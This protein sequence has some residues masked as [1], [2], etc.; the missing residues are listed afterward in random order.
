MDRF[1]EWRLLR[2][3]PAVVVH[4]AKSHT[5]CSG[6]GGL[7]I[8]GIRTGLMMRVAHGCGHCPSRIQ[9]GNNDGSKAEQ[10]SGD[11][12]GQPVSPI[13]SPG[14]PPTEVSISFVF[15]AEH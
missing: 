2:F 6:S 4:A 7:G 9:A 13:V 14:R 8:A 15:V 10:S 12:G 1:T 3:D 5:E 11:A